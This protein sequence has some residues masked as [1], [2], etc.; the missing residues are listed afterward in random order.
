MNDT[1]ARETADIISLGSVNADFQVR[2]DRRPAESETLLGRDFVRLGGGKAANVALIARKLGREVRLLARVGE[3]DL[4][5][6]ALG[7]LRRAGIDL[8]GVG[9]VDGC[10]TGVAMIMVPP[11][12]KKGIVLAPN[13]N[14]AW[15]DRD[16]PGLSRHIEAAA[17][18]AVL[19]LDCEIPRFI[20]E[21]AVAAAR[22]R[23]LTC[24]LDPSPAERAGGDLL[25]LVDV[26]TPN[27]A[28]AETLTGIRVTDAGSAARAA[29]R[30]LACG[31]SAVL[32]KL[33]DGGCV[34][35]HGRR[36]VRVE[37]AP[38]DVIDTTGAGD[39][40]AGALAV[41]LF[42]QRGIVEGARYAVAAARLA[43]GGYGSQPAYPDRDALE[44]ALERTTLREL[45]T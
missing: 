17:E 35:L 34:S 39:A 36:I 10:G 44:Q 1:R 5:E 45:A 43:V 23:G 33:P 9:R 40:F 2:I 13:A 27:P 12:G 42:E 3:D 26:V 20:A 7:P 19:V 22:Q 37:S 38:G 18:G 31:P 28:E 4:A 8:A 11:D 29:E 25:A 32:A 16:L 14:E 24:V 21:A 41:A 15:T 30:I 6:Q